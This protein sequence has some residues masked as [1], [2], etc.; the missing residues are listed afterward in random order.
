MANQNKVSAI[1]D[2]LALPKLHELIIQA[3]EPADF[4]DLSI[5]N[6]KPK[7]L[8]FLQQSVAGK[9]VTLKALEKEAAKLVA[10]AKAVSTEPKAAKKGGAQ[11]GSGRPKTAIKFEAE[12][13]ITV[14]YRDKDGNP[15][16][17]KR[18]VSAERFN[19]YKN[20]MTVEAA[21]QAGVRSG[22]LDWD[23]KHEYISIA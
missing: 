15:G 18:G 1:I 12:Q 20:N 2:G 19:L 8:A 14:T 13:K 21:L 22:D 3:M 7:A 11:P 4:G 17:P 9:T 6:S 23:V 10:P 16:N 5:Y